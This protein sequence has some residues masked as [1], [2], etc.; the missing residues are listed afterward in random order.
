MSRFVR[1]VAGAFPA[2]AQHSLITMAVVLGI[3]VA[4]AVVSARFL[5]AAGRGELAAA[6]AW[7]S[8]AASVAILGL[9]ARRSPS[10]P[11]STDRR[12]HAAAAGIV[13]AVVL[14]VAAS[15]CFV[16]GVSVVVVP[17]P[18]HVLVYSFALP[19]LTVLHGGQ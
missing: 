15:L 3:G 9:A 13:S 2:G 17:I 19:S 16:A 4:S 18:A 5:G 6:V 14:G 1:V 8:V 7:V 12:A 10:S 11:P